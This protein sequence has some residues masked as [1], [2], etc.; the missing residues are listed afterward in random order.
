[1]KNIVIILSSALLLSAC[2]SDPRDPLQIGADVIGREADRRE[3]DQ[4]Q[5]ERFAEGLEYQRKR[6]QLSDNI[7]KLTERQSHQE[8]LQ[9]RRPPAD[10]RF[11]RR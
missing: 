5:R 6:N 4:A 2:G 9:E 11:P 8:R 10:F 3:R 7:S 1:M